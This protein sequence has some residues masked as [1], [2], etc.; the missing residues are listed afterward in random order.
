MRIK[1]HFIKWALLFFLLASL[2]QTYSLLNSHFTHTDDTGVAETLLIRT[3]GG[4]ACPEVL[5][6]I[7]K[8]LQTS[9]AYVKAPI[10]TLD[11]WR[12]RLF[13]IPG[14]W[15]YAPFQ[16]WFTQALLDPRV[17]HSYEQIK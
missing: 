17:T 9:L 3:P 14:Q 7:E 1:H 4:S 10:C 15:T 16:F 11:L 2:W 12:S 5:T 8:K 6:K 13:I